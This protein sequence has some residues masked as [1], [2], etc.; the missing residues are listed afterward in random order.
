MAIRT[1]KDCKKEFEAKSTYGS[2]YPRR[3]C[4]ECAKERK[5]SYA[6]IHNITASDCEDE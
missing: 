3:Y 4:D 1:C 5:K 2:K 6:D